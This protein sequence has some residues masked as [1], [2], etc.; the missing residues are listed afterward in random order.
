MEYPTSQALIDDLR[1]C[2]RLTD[3]TVDVTEP[4]RFRTRYLD[5]LTR[6]AVFDADDVKQLA[7]WIIWEAGLHLGVRAASI[8]E[9]YA[10]RGRGAWPYGTVPAFNIRGLTYD[11]ARAAVR[12]AK[13]LSVG[14]Y[15]FEIARSE[16]GYTEQRPGEYAAVVLAAALREGQRGPVF[17]QGDH[18]QVNLRRYAADPDREIGYVSMLTEEAIASGFF[19]I[20]IDTS[21]LVDL[22]HPTVPEQQRL[23]YERAAELAALIRRS[24]PRGVTISIGGE[25]G[26]VGGKNSTVEELRAFLDGFNRELARRCGPDVRGISKISVQ[27]GTKHGGVV[28]P[29]GEIARVA[30]DFE[31]LRELSRVAREEYGLAGAVQHGASTL[32]EEAFDK[33]P[34]VGCAEVHLATGFQNLLCDHAAFP[35]DLKREMYAWLREHAAAERKEGMTD[36]Q[37]FYTTRKTAMGPFKAKLWT[38]PASARDAIAAALEERFAFLF[39]KLAVASSRRL[40]DEIVSPVDM[41]RPAPAAVP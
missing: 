2:L 25:I 35:A 20:D 15:I 7:R 34:E 27:T 41:H 3:G 12:A 29:S 38:M 36:E 18:F 1:G 26:E 32:P 11:T 10:A 19:N 17:I 23:N 16:I 30:L 28:L 9:L 40:V 31:T 22:S 37:F 21:T 8:D 13:R 39:E 24:Q 33:F 14:A 5:R 4:E 6:S